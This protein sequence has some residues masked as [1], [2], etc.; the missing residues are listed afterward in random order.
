MKIE[1]AYIKNFRILKEI[2]VDFE[3][4]LSVVIGKNNAGK[5]SFLAILEKF[6]ASSKPEFAF[7]DFSITEQQAICALEDTEKNVEE[8][9]E[10]LLSLKLYISYTDDDDISKASEFLLDL[11]VD[12]KYFVLLEE[13]VLTFE[14]YQKLVSDYKMYK[15]SVSGR[16]FRDYVSRNIN[17]YF[18][19]RIRALEYDNEANAKDISLETVN[20]VIS[21][22]TIGARR[23][24]DNEQGK[25]KSLSVLANRYYRNIGSDTAFPSLQQQLI[26]TDKKLTEEYKTIFADVV[27]EI[28]EMSYSPTEAEISIISSL[29]DRPIFQDNTIVKYL[30]DD[31]LLPEDYNG[32]GYLNLFAIMFDIRI[33][34]DR[35]AK[36]NSP[37][38][39]PTPINLLFI[40]E[41]EAHTHPQMQYVFIMNIKQI[42][43]KQR[44][45][46]AGFNLQTIISTHSSH[47]V[48]QCDFQDIKY[49]YR[50][51][52]ETNSVKSRSLKRLHSAMVTTKV[53]ATEDEEKAKQE[54]QKVEEEAAFRFV[55]Q[56]VTLQRAEMFFADK[57]ILIEGDTER[58]LISAMMKKYDDSKKAD[59]AYVPLLSQN[60][61]VIEVG[62]YAKVFSIFLG[63]IGIKNVIFTDL[64][65]AKKNE[66][67]R[68][69]GCGFTD[70][71]LTTNASIHHFLG[72]DVI[73]E[74]VA[75]TSDERTFEYNAETK[76]W[77]QDNDG[78][79]R[80]C[81]QRKENDYQA[82]SFED[83]F[84]SQNL[85]FVV[86]NKDTFQG[87]KCISELVETATDFYDLADKCIKSKT[88]FA[89]DILM[90]G[91]SNN[92][93]WVTPKYIEEGL[94][95]LS[96]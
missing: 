55:K 65:C 63:F 54:K 82:S 19:V 52:G 73:S 22:Q 27:K 78:H 46:T 80:I 16:D 62:A 13:F 31:T 24:V 9:A 53:T 95:W 38:E 21:M 4:A 61:S 91:D 71:T 28:K 42:L 89:L 81:Y 48:S 83:A 66:N 37:D 60:I 39:R 90:N 75:K 86:L 56:Y 18:S 36:K 25:G 44:D 10:A 14:K 72:T 23:D 30:H 92:E 1:R 2:E 8:Y 68:S 7:D 11:D 87:L 96:M 51:I 84:L 47:I 40:E 94:E 57:A 85:K 43:K 12:K 5:T 70:A 15:E 74:V 35:L 26:E 88:T 64:D 45:K 29:I 76:L 33:K 17:R 3:D 58:M 93:Q 20:Q 6:L 41:P 59:S 50:V 69:E 32:L 77:R 79:L 49:F 67:N 34:L